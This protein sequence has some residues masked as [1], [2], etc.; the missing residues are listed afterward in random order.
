MSRPSFADVHLEADLED[1]SLDPQ[2]QEDPIDPPD[3]DT[4]FRLLVMGDFSGR[5][6]RGVREAS[7]L[8]LRRPI[9]VDRDNI[10]AIL[11]KLD[12]EVWLERAD[13]KQPPLTISFRELDDFLPDRLYARIPDFAALASVEPEPEPLTPPRAASAPSVPP[14]NLLSGASLLEQAME[15]TESAAPARLDDP[16]SAYIRSIV[17]PHLEPK[18][19]ARHAGLEAARDEQISS[20]MR[21]VLHHPAFQAVEAAWRSLFWLVRSLETGPQLRVYLLDVTRE[22]LADDL[23]HSSDLRQ[24][25]LHRLLVQE[26]IGTP[27]A[28]PWATLVGN[29]SFGPGIEDLSLLG[30]IGLLAAQARAAFLAGGKSTLLG[31]DSP[32]APPDPDTWRGLTG[33]AAEGWQFLRRF[34]EARFIGLVLPRVLLRLPYGRHFEAPTQ[35]AFE[36]FATGW[37]HRNYLWGNGAFAAAYLIGAAFAE[38]GWS[39]RPGLRLDIDGLPL[40]V[41]KQDDEAVSQPVCEV[42]LTDEA[43]EQALNHGVM[44]LLSY[45]DADIAHLA[46]FRSIAEPPARLAGPWG[47]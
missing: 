23:L 5:A 39:V 17:E 33:S 11:E 3:E 10:E 2:A 47:S 38:Y 7:R 34:P 42:L 26:T 9:L 41:Y 14:E 36:E 4:P 13:P 27:G 28:A 22:E 43:A 24:T 30:R 40:H 21:Q 16:M 20:L 1:D 46:G 12:V 45:K 6:S 37:Q 19:S 18:K 35:F 44:P 25:G 32:D 31:C 29:Y 15:A 8:G